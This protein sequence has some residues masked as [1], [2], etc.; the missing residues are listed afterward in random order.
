MELSDWIA[1]R[2]RSAVRRVRTV[3]LSLAAVLFALTAWLGWREVKLA[4]LPKYV[5]EAV[6]AEEHNGA[7]LRLKKLSA[8][9]YLAKVREN[10]LLSDM[11]AQRDLSGPCLQLD[12]MRGLDASSPCVVAW[13]SFL[14]NIWNT[15]FTIDA[16]PIWV[17]MLRD[18]W[19]APYL[20]DQS[21]SSCGKF[22][23]WCP[24][25]TVRSAG[26]DGKGDTGDDIIEAVPNHV[27]PSLINKPTNPSASQ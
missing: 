19:G 22:G 12:C 25:D 18:P 16:P 24:P 20:L 10:S 17:D 4:P 5:G 21:E 27:G 11:T 8:I 7:R 2:E 1:S 6:Q 23:E 14:M 15:A 3:G 13:E 26:V 9:I